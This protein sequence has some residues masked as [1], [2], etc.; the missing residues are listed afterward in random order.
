[1]VSA[2]IALLSFATWLGYKNYQYNEML[3]A[4][5]DQVHLEYKQVL[6]KQNFDIEE[7][8]SIIEPL[9]VLEK[10]YQRFEAQEQDKPWYVL[11]FIVSIDR[12][13][14]YRKLYQQQ[15]VLALQPTLTSYLEEELFVYLELEDYLTVLN[16]ENVYQSYASANT[17][18]QTIIIEYFRESFLNSG[19]M[20]HEQI[21]DF[22]ILLNDLFTLGYQP[23]A[24]NNELVAIV[25]AEI[26]TQNRFQLL[27]QYIESL[28]EFS[29]LNDVRS[30]VFGQD[31][32]QSGGKDLLYFDQSHSSFLVPNLYTP[33]GLLQL[34]F[35]P[36]SGFFKH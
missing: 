27:Y 14:H 28:P 5:F 2:G 7:P 3:H 35:I 34:S 24:V 26:S 31:A 1:M 32:P 10:A 23:F 12:E 9:M 30:I 17:D 22:T 29:R 33:G 8:S 6:N 20:T 36:D 18:N 19:V 25:D 13:K 21:S 15:L 16:I 4:E 11:P